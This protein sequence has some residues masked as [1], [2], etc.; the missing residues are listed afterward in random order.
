MA[1]DLSFGFATM[2]EL[3]PPINRRSLLRIAILGAPVIFGGCGTP[4]KE[5]LQKMKSQ[6]RLQQERIEARR[7]ML[8][9]VKRG[10][11]AMPSEKP[12]LKRKIH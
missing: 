12:S 10:D 2:S 11:K 5:E 8:H 4:S 9:R 3:K 7:G 6:R 1:L